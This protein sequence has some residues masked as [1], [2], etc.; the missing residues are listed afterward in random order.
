MRSDTHPDTLAPDTPAAPV[1]ARTPRRASAE[2]EREELREILLWL[3]AAF[4]PDPAGGRPGLV[5]TGWIDRR[6][7]ATWRRR[8]LRAGRS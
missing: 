4:R 5:Q 7:I 2:A 6:I 8:V 1:P 3:L